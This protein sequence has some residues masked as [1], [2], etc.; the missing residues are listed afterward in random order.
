VM[1]TISTRLKAEIIVLLCAAAFAGCFG[2]DVT[3][4]EPCI[5]RIDFGPQHHGAPD[6]VDLLLVLDSAPS[7]RAA[8][9]ALATQLPAFVEALANGNPPE[10]EA[11]HDPRL[12]PFNPQSLHVGV[13]TADM[14]LRD[15]DAVLAAQE[16]GLACDLMG[17]DAVLRVAG[18]GCT[19]SALEADIGR[20]LIF[21]PYEGDTSAVTSDV[22]C[23]AAVGAAGCFA[24]Q[25]LEAA[26]TAL[27]P[28]D[29]ALTFFDGDSG[30]GNPD[31][32]NRGFVRGGSLLLIVVVTDG[33]DCSLA[34]GSLHDPDH[35]T[36][37]G[38]RHVRCALPQNGSALHLLARY[39]DGLRALRSERPALVLLSLIAGIPAG[40]AQQAGE[41]ATD[42]HDR[43]LAHPD[44]QL[45]V[46]IPGTLDDPVEG[47]VL[48][49]DDPLLRPADPATLDL[50]DLG[51]DAV[52]WPACIRPVPSQLER[53]TAAPAI[54]LVRAA[55][56]LEVAGLQTLVSSICEEHPQEPGHLDLSGALHN[57]LELLVKTLAHACLP[58]PL[59]TDDDGRVDCQLMEVQPEV[60]ACPPDARHRISFTPGAEPAP[61]SLLS[62]E[63]G[64]LAGA[65]PPDTIP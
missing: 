3:P 32:A 14:G 45:R 28:S 36:Y 29:S 46:G 19:P 41:S 6:A 47:T 65:C 35:P 52:V 63:C 23:L 48:D 27:T 37:E 18:E 38:G 1:H 44:M 34:D 49:W 9:E 43:V 15:D 59:A 57:T 8:H 55:R 64:P 60:D 2:R 22:A 53:D 17:D 21:D 20:F 11:G 25:P 50:E 30:H 12:P 16:D 42:F 10:G 61:G 4:L 33:D 13:I 39:A 51:D 7:M 40:M 58:R 31:G 62:L 5:L 24:R 56:S 54:R 26:L